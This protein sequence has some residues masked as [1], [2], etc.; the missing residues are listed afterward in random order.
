MNEK[1]NLKALLSIIGKEYPKLTANQR[2]K[3]ARILLKYLELL[4]GSGIEDVSDYLE[5]NR[6]ALVNLL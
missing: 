5:T 4:E 6:E 3:L 2:R 1:T